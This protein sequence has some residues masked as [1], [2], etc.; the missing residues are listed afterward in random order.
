MTIAGCDPEARLQ[1]H[2]C[3][4]C[5]TPDTSPIYELTAVPVQSTILL[6]SREAALSFPTGDIELRW[7]AECG[8]AYNVR[9][10]PHRVRYGRGYED[11][12]GNSPTFLRFATKLA[13]GWIARYGLNGKHLVEI[14]CGKGDFL[15]LMCAEGQCSGTGY[16]P[17][18]VSGREE[19][20][21]GLSF[22]AE[23]F[24]EAHGSLAADFLI[25]RHTLEHIGSVGAFLTMIRRACGDSRTIRLGFEVPDFSRIMREGAFWDVYYEHASY[26]TLGSLAR[27]FARAGFDVL[28]L[29]RAYGDQYLILEAAPADGRPAPPPPQ[30]GDLQATAVLVGRFREEGVGQ[31]QAWRTLF[32]EWR[33]RDR[34]VALW[35]SGSKAVGFL[36]TVGGP[37]IVDYVVDIN[38]QRH[39]YYMPGCAAPIVAPERLC[40]HIPDIVI[41]M[42]PIYRDEIAGQINDMGIAAEILTVDAPQSVHQREHTA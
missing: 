10:D 39:G 15:R 38:P 18:F 30:A 9:F 6:S 24:T 1:G 8:L 34:R 27:A 14:G 26:F 35:G 41:V 23:D 2:K 28:D 13:R 3:P 31:V 21:P 17:A 33:A 42:N 19:D 32:D 4:S 37:R 22:L 36:T 40:D 5:D 20:P 7:C 16:D 12:Q 11:S 25:C 29:R